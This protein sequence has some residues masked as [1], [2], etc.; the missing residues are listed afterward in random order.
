MKIRSDLGSCHRIPAIKIQVELPDPL[1]H[2]LTEVPEIDRLPYFNTKDQAGLTFIRQVQEKLIKMPS[3][4][5]TENLAEIAKPIAIQMTQLKPVLSNTFESYM[6]FKFAL[7]MGVVSF[8]V[9]LALH[10]LCMYLYHRFSSVR[11]LVPNF[12]KVGKQKVPVKPMVV[13]DRTHSRKIAGET[14]KWEKRAHV[15]MKKS[16]SENSLIPPDTER[17]EEFMERRKSLCSVYTKGD[18]TN[19][20]EEVNV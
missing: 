4:R 11:R 2:L 13:V 19:D 5:K 18:S 8:L 9:S 16:E 20:F 3:M 10:L 6:P 12:I 7:L 1:K 14:D 17:E 15:V